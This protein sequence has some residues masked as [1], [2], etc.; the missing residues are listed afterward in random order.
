MTPKERIEQVLEAIR[1]ALQADGGD[2]ELVAFDEEDGSVHL[3]L[4]G[5]C[6]CCPFSEMTLKQ[7]IQRRILGAVPEAKS[8]FA[9]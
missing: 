1:P 5:A 6:G 3:R 9:T 8:V 4:T 2:V 7:G